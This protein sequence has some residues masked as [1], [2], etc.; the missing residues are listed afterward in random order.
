MVLE[1]ILLIIR[2]ISL[3]TTIYNLNIILLKNI[4]F[5]MKN[6]DNIILSNR[7]IQIVFFYTLIYNLSK[8]I[9]LTSIIG[10]FHFIIQFY[11][12]PKKVKNK[13]KDIKKPLPINTRKITRRTTTIRPIETTNAQTTTPLEITTDDQSYNTMVV[14]NN[15]YIELNTLSI[16]ILQAILVLL[17][18]CTFTTN[19]YIIIII[20]IIFT[21]NNYIV[22]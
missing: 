14:K 6:N 7:Y 17:M 8:D 9:Y 3:T 4:G 19:I 22:S 18:S 21:F 16:K 11:L 1:D 12:T 13:K 2:N 15:I 10:T 5:R 20:I